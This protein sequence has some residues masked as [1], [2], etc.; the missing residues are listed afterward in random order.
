[1]QAAR[2]VGTVHWIWADSACSLDSPALAKALLLGWT[3][4]GVAGH[5]I[6]VRGLGRDGPADLGLAAFT[7]GCWLGAGAGGCCGRRGC[8]TPD[9]AHAGLP[10]PVRQA[11]LGLCNLGLSAGVSTNGCLPAALVAV[12]AQQNDG[13]V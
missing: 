3:D 9:L 12:A 7:V 5:R 10:H 4:L 6:L 13:R 8:Q 1:M 2:S 11:L